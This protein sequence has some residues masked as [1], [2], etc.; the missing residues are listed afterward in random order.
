MLPKLKDFF[1]KKHK[2]LTLE[3]ARLLPSFYLYTKGVFAYKDEDGY[4]YW[5]LIKDGI[6]LLAGLQATYCYWY[7]KGVFKHRDEHY[8]M[9]HINIFKRDCS[10]KY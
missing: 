10:I 4:G 7:A 9:H 8:Y 5:H 2:I 1:K 6:D 3:E